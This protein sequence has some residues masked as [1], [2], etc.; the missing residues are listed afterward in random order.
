MKL[1]ENATFEAVNSNLCA[2]EH[3]SSLKKID[4]RIESYSCKMAGNDKRL[5]KH[6]SEENKEAPGGLQA[7]SPPQSI[8]GSWTYSHS[9]SSAVVYGSSVEMDDNMGGY[10]LCDTIPTKTLFYLISTLNA[11]FSPDYDFSSTESREFSREPSLQAVTQAINTQLFGGQVGRLE[12]K[13]WQAVDGEID[14]KECQIYSYNPDMSS[15]PFGEEGCVWSF[16]YFFYNP[17]LKRVVFF[18]C[19][20]KSRSAFGDSGI[21][22]DDSDEMSYGMADAMSRFDDNM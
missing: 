20:A 8:V 18:T 19:R 4:G 15:D 6:L 9:P 16:N 7:L 10:Q 17:K 1:L 12:D 3:P 5:Y 14:L 22:M 13:L 2:M 11:S 21:D